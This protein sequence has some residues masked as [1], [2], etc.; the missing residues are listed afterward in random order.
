[1]IITLKPSG[2]KVTLKEFY[3]MY[4]HAILFLLVMSVYIITLVAYLVIRFVP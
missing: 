1:M 3:R 2:R 4:P